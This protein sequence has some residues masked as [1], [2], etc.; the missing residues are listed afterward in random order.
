MAIIKGIEDG[1]RN[2]WYV[3]RRKDID[4]LLLNIQS[5]AT[6]SGFGGSIKTVGVALS[7]ETTNLTVGAAKITFRMP[8]GMTLTEV[9]ANVNTASTGADIIVD[10]K[11]GG[12]SIFTTNLLHIDDGAETSVGSS[13]TPNITTSALTDN[14]EITMDLNQTGAI[15]PGNGLKVWLIGT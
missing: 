13:T 11:Q 3:V 10:I 15:T 1:S 4:E 12:S 7:D 2:P 5:W 8:Y 14:A 6:S 9:R